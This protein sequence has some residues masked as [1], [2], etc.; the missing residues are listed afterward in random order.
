MCGRYVSVSSPTILADRFA[1]E[2]VRVT[3]KEPDYNVTP[4]AEV[5]IVAVSR[6]RRVLDLVRWGLVPS[7]A[8]ELSIGD[9]QI[10]A[11]A[12]SVTTKP[13][14]KRA[15][16]KRRAIV[17][18]DGFYE[19][20]P[21]P[22]R[23]QKQPWFIRRRDGEPLAFAGLWEIWHDPARRDDAPRIRSCTIITTDANDVVQPLHD[24][25]PV[26]LPESEWDRWLDPT[27]Q[28]ID[29][30]RT[31][32]VPAPAAA[33]EAWPVTSLVNKADNNGPE[34]LEAVEVSSV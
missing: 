3:D 15:F 6:G 10:N 30:L 24:R 12:S 29:V 13:A 19:W 27:F 20:Q 2:E 1:V 26:V 4:R 21:V 23:K 18:A 17:P 9:R 25:M 22:G 11:R 14:Y 31:L 28:D 7:W 33:F 8:K 5:P 34:L 32:L 16:V